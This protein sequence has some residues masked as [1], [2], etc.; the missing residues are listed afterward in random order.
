M[1][2]ASAGSASGLAASARSRIATPS[3]GRSMPTSEDSMRAAYRR[4]NGSGVV[5]TPR[6]RC[7]I[8]G[9]RS[10]VSASA[11][12]SSS[13]TAGRSVWLR[14]LEQ[15][16]PQVGDR[17][18]GRAARERFARRLAQPL[19]R[20]RRRGGLGLQQV[21]GDALRASRPRRPAAAPRAGGR[22]RG[23]RGRAPRAPPRGRSRA[24]SCSRRSGSRI[25][26]AA[27]RVGRVG[28][29]ALVELGDA[30]RVSEQRAVAEHR[31]G[32]GER[33]RRCGEAGRGARGSPPRRRAGPRRAPRP[34]RPAR[35]RA[36]RRRARAGRTGCRRSAREQRAQ[37]ASGASGT[38]S[39]TSRA[40][41]STFSGASCSGGSASSGATATPPGSPGGRA[42]TTSSTGRS[43]TRPLR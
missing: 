20:P 32:A 24:R 7:S 43:C 41:S 16:P 39:R 26:P 5:S 12:P 37:S 27:Q 31:G 25:R 14:R 36:A 1:W 4:A 35:R 8:A 30:R 40:A 42:A 11:R 23:R 17:G 10:S 15:R 18:V 33:P 13:R 6:R 34:R 19:A 22:P 38:A 9:S 21:R 2:T 28:G 3:A 29:G